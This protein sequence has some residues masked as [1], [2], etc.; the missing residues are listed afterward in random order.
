M[1][2]SERDFEVVD[3]REVRHRQTGATWTTD[4]YVNVDDTGTS[5][6]VN[7]GRAGEGYFPTVA[8]LTPHAVALLRKLARH[9][10]S[11]RR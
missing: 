8:E 10:N 2:I 5:V 1:T 3:V 4:H 11:E 9:A 6:T 7:P